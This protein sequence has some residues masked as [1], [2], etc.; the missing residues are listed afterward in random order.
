M[1]DN[2][3]IEEWVNSYFQGL[4][5][6]MNPLYAR[7]DMKEVLK[8]LEAIPFDQLVAR[9]LAEESLEVIELA[10]EL[11]KDMGDRETEYL[12]AYVVKE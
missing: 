3:E 4:F 8:S 7:A 5:S 11:I 9:E 12:R 6:M 1:A 10:M 2:D